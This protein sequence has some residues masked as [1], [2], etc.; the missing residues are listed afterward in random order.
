MAR[1]VSGAY[2][3]RVPSLPSKILSRAHLLRALVRANWI[4]A[5]AARD[6]GTSRQAVYDAMWRYQV[7]RKRNETA[8]LEHYRK[9]GG[10]RK[11]AV[12]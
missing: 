11:A 7:P 4:I 3:S 2:I 8:L 9:V 10:K 6:L 5:E 12:A 1:R